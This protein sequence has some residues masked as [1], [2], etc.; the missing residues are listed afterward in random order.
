MVAQRQLCNNQ[1][2]FYIR[3]AAFGRTVVVLQEQY[4]G[5]RLARESI[6][7]DLEDAMEAASNDNLFPSNVVKDVEHTLQHPAT[8]IQTT[9]WGYVCRR[10]YI[11]LRNAVTSIQETYCAQMVKRQHRFHV[12]ASHPDGLAHSL[13]EGGGHGG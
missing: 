12:S 9:V 3:W 11:I 4:C 5:R 8:L 13:D 10:H 1:P 6:A 7:N 2:I